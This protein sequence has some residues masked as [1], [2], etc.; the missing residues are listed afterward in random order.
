MI[1]RLLP[2]LLCFGLAVPFVPVA[3]AG[4][5]FDEIAG[6]LGLSATQ[7]TQVADIV[8]Q[9]KE[10]RIA[11]KARS[12]SARLQLEHLLTQA[13]VDE[14]AVMKAL[15]EVNAASADLR[16]NRIEQI[17]AIRKVLSPEQWSQLSGLWK[18]NREDR[19]GRHDDED[20]DE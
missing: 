9:S 1:T 3:H 20:E 18:D 6:T 10:K 7:K 15:D 4:D 8:Y 12:A 19:R 13:T 14:R 16:R 5:R 11:I 2:F 17:L